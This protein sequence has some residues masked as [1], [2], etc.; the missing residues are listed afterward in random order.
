VGRETIGDRVWRYEHAGYTIRERGPHGVVLDI[1]RSLSVLGW[2]VAFVSFLGLLWYLFIQI[3]SGFH[4]DWVSIRLGPGGHIAEDGPGAAHVRRRR[5]RSGRRWG[6]IGAFFLIFCLILGLILAVVGGLLL[7]NDEYQ[8]A[9]RE[10][11]PE[12]DLLQDQ[13]NEGPADPDDVDLME[14]AGVVFGLLG[15]ITLIGLWAGAT[16][17]IVG[18]IHANTY[19]VPVPPLPGYR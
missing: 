2:L 4:K 15:G 8:A 3:G 19:H 18:Y 12:V 11:Y 17:A 13:L 6:L 1:G 9:L 14:T 7:S 10:A 5:S 16:L